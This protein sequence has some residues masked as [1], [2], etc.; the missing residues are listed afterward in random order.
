MII[1]INY[2]LISQEEHHILPESTLYFYLLHTKVLQCL[3]HRYN[4]RR[5]DEECGC[6]LLNGLA[7]DFYCLDPD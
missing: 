4:P 5:Q 3:H 6:F 7:I 1:K 2:L